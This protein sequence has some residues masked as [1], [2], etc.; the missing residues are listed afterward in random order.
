M[1]KILSFLAVSLLFLN[2]F[3]STGCEEDTPTPEVKDPPFLVLS[4]DKLIDNDVFTVFQS[5]VAPVSFTL[6]G[7][8]GTDALNTIT[9]SGVDDLSQLTSTGISGIGSNTVLITDAGEKL[10]FTWDM[11][12]TFDNAIGDHTVTF[13]LADEGGLVDDVSFTISVVEDPG[14]PI[15]TTLTTVFLVNQQSN[16]AGTGSLDLDDGKGSGVTSDGDVPKEE[17]EIRDMGI[18]CTIP[19]T[20]FNWRKQI[21]GF[22]G[23]ELRTV[24][25]TQLPETFSFD[26]VQIKEDIQSAFDTGTPGVSSDAVDPLCNTT[27]TVDYTSDVLSVGD[28]LAVKKGDT[29]Y[30]I[31]VD[32]INEDGGS[33]N[34]NEDY[35]TLSIKH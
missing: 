6:D 8:P 19:S 10:G 34:T 4:S 21:G 17:A 29:Y 30:L 35:Y 18:D 27:A 26:G 7:T 32:E 24:D 16:M 23:T 31:R 22:N 9:I 5:E 3:V 13:E 20:D 12:Y 15:D 33:A 2:L 25:V 11:T 14:T 28:L 1:K